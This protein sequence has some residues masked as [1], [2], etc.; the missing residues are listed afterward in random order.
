MYLPSIVIVGF[1]F[2]RRRALATGIAVCGSGVGT[3]IFAPFS[4]LLLDYFGW[5]GGNQILAGVILNGIVCGAVFRPLE[6]PRKEENSLTVEV[7]LRNTE[8]PRRRRY[9]QR[10]LIMQ[11]IIDEK[12]RQRTI[13]TGSLDGTIITKDNQL[14][15]P[16]ELSVGE[17]VNSLKLT[18]G[19]GV[20]ETIP[21]VVIP[22]TADR[23]NT[24]PTAE[25]GVAPIGQGLENDTRNCSVPYFHVLEPPSQTVEHSVPVVESSGQIV[26]PPQDSGEL[27]TSELT[28]SSDDDTA[29]ISKDFTPFR[30][31]SN[32]RPPSWLSSASADLPETELVS[33]MRPEPPPPIT[34]PLYRHDTFYSGSVLNIPDVRRNPEIT[35]YASIPS[36]PQTG[37]GRTS[38]CSNMAP[39]LAVL[40]AMLDF[41][42]L[43]S[44]TF[45]LLCTALVMPFIGRQPSIVL[46]WNACMY[47]IRLHLLLSVSVCVCLSVS[48]CVCLS[49]H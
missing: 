13:S 23:S 20:L 32:F 4:R 2:E 38:V 28:F 18:G 1:Y 7:E 39:A 30:R 36:M 25:T 12:K 19:Q 17:S 24:R 45:A 41:N 35:T 5:R 49:V 22:P 43:R 16:S 33:D 42:L 48:V 26:E 37:N 44:F 21:E 10:G 11:K 9:V 8:L 27:Y 46:H 14:I 31:T 40:K 6:G 3:F 47:I 29:E 15:R 34:R